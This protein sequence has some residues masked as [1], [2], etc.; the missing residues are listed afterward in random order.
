MPLTREFKDTVQ[1]RAQTEPAFRDALLVEAVECLLSGDVETGKA[2]LRHYI[3]AAIGFD[4]LG[5]LTSKPPKSL[6]RMFSPTGNP[7]AGNMFDVLSQ[8]Q[9]HEC[10]QLEVKV[11]R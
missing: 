6:M 7:Q 1:A 10:T 4:Q 9:S 5:A 2:M 3:N 11:V 8:I